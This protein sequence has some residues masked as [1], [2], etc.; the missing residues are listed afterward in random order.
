[1]HALGSSCARLSVHNLVGDLS[2]VIARWLSWLCDSQVRAVQEPNPACAL[3]GYA[4]AWQ[5]HQVLLI[6][7]DLSGGATACALPSSGT[8]CCLT[9]SCFHQVGGH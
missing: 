6:A 7:C 8:A 2:C 1:M 4:P 3:P 5:H 9:V